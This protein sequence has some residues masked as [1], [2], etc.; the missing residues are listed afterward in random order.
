M[1]KEQPLRL[2]K[3]IRNKDKNRKKG[4]TA[5]R[6]PQGPALLGTS[7][8]DEPSGDGVDVLDGGFEAYGDP[9]GAELYLPVP[10]VS[11]NR[12]PS[13]SAI[14]ALI[15]NALVTTN[16]TGVIVDFF[17]GFVLKN[18]PRIGSLG[19]AGD[20]PGGNVVP[21]CFDMEMF[22]PGMDRTDS[23]PG[24]WLYIHVALSTV[25]APMTKDGVM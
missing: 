22:V 24:G 23:L 19:A 9:Y 25:D 2:N 21:D 20:S 8:Y 13:F 12:S 18:W 17:L 4:S 15:P 11:P 5:P 10:S 6:P 14:S 1:V 16:G 7:A 3:R